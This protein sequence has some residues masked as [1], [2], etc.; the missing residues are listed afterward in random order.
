MSDRVIRPAEACRMLARCSMAALYSWLAS[1]PPDLPTLPRP[2]CVG[3]NSVGWLESELLTYM[4]SLPPTPALPRA[5]R[6]KAK[7][8]PK[9]CAMSAEPRDDGGAVTRERARDAGAS[10]SRRRASVDRLHRRH[11]SRWPGSVALAVDAP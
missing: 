7:E 10:F 8:R 1:P 6:R 11:V 2:R 4:Q 3:P 9:E 5:T